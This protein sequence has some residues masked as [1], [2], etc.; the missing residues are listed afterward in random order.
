MDKNVLDKMLRPKTVAVVGA[1]ATPGK[2][3]YTV[4]NNL[5]KGG[6]TGKIYP[7]NP[8]CTEILGLKCYPSISEVPGEVDSAIITIPAKAMSEVTEACG[9]KG[10]KGLIVI[11]SGF[12]ESGRKDLED[13]MLEIAAKYKM[14][15]LGP[16]IVGSLSNSD[17]FNGS[18]A[19]GLPLPGKASLVTQSG[20]LLIAIDMATYTRK[21]GF[22]KL[23]SIGNMADVDFADL[24]EWFDEDDNTTCV[25]LYIEGMKNGRKF[26]DAARKSSKP[27]VALKSGVSAHGSAAAASHTGSLAG[28]AK[29]YNS[30]FKQAG[31][32]QAQ[33]LNDL[34]N[35]TLTLSQQPP[36][37]GEN[38]LILTNGGGVG[39]L[40]TD[41]A[42][43][44]GI[45]LHFA[46]ADVQTE[47]KKHMPEFGSAKNPVDMTGMAGNDWYYQTTKFS[48]A[49][50]WTD[51][52]VVLYCET[53]MT[54][55][56]EIA[57]SIKQA[58]DDS[59]VTGKPITV[60]FV[61]GEKSDQAMGWLVENGIPAFGG[62]DIAVNAM[63]A[64]RE[65]ARLQENKS[66]GAYN[67]D[68]SA[69]KT[70]LAIFAQARAEK[71][72]SLTEIEA[73]EVFKAYGMPVTKIALAKSEDEAVALGNKIGFPLV[74]KIVSP[75][76]LHKSDAGGVKVNIK[77]DAG[78]REAYQTILKNAKAYKADANIHGIAIQEM[79][80]WGTEVILG[81]VNDAAFGPTV[82]F[83]LGGIFVEVLK[84]VTF[85][86]TPFTKSEAAEMIGEIKGAAIL[87]GARGEKPK[88]RA[89]LAET[90]YNYS[91]M[92]HDLDDEIKES[93]AN[94]VLVYEDG[95]GLKVA[96]ARIILKTK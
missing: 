18:F 74:L 62:P 9:K 56:F 42:E 15:I 23:I 44:Y 37:K 78:I 94:P 67:C 75:D 72:D 30:A 73:K 88:D 40:A 25:S 17:K 79:A 93:D 32:I 77:D 8:T 59:G 21:I 64:L 38:L 5:I 35:R 92:I 52:L 51:G 14:R 49:H 65:Y 26:I 89:M 33:D 60:S 3:G 48:Y 69:K 57:K 55:P 31:V 1:S 47:L 7:I 16:N 10:V 28:A 45:P 84:D 61:G 39:V 63:A 87:A 24:I 46:P 95:Q 11:T 34:F 22:D 20:A 53:A 13:E 41:A 71:R 36:M 90:I 91:C 66:D 76:I 2:I 4:I 68:E 85:R 27:I 12:S 96:D 6:Y 29:I 43:K 80:P 54:N 50:D 83:G 19:P 81:S 70:A 86:V 58:V 82:M